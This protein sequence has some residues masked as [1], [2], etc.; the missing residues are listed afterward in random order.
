MTDA[1][2]NKLKD[3][4]ERNPELLR[5]AR[6]KIHPQVRSLIIWKDI[7]IQLGKDYTWP[8]LKRASVGLVPLLEVPELRPIIVK[9]ILRCGL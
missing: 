7:K 6:M 9:E 4:L 3:A 5:W 8:C 1:Q 2:K